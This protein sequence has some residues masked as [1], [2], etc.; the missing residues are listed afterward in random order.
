MHIA[1][2]LCMLFNLMVARNITPDDGMQEDVDDMKAG[3][4]QA[5]QAVVQ[6]EGQDG[7]RTIRLQHH[8]WHI[9]AVTMMDTMTMV[10]DDDG[11]NSSSRG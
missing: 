5:V 3:H 7:E 6:A 11:G 9:N 4:V 10:V 2:Q 8:A 1:L